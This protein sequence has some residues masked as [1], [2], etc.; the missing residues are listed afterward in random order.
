MS[1]EEIILEN[2]RHSERRYHLFKAALILFCSVS[3]LLFI[4]YE[5]NKSTNAVNAKNHRVEQ[6]LRCSLPAFTPQNYP[7]AE[8]IINKCLKE[9][10]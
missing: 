4:G 9:N 2:L 3:I 10:S 1:G 8:K 6:L 7:E 5:A